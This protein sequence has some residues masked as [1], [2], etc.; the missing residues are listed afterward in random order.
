[1]R[2]PRRKAEETRQ[3][4]L[5]IAEKLFRRHGIA[6]TSVA[7]IA[8]E[9]A[10]SPANVFKHFHSKTALVDAICERHVSRMIEQFTSM[11]EPAPAPERLAR[12]VCRLM[13]THLQHI[14]ENPFFLEMIFVM[15]DTQLHSGRRY[16]ALIE[17]LFGDLIRQGAESG[18]YRCTD[19]AATS[20]Y[21]SAAFVSVLHPVFL[22]DADRD[23]LR[24]RCTGLAALVNAALQN[25]LAK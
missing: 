14:R 6:K 10:M 15:S 18:V 11:D 13:E 12:V 3:D 4:I 7:D 16:G 20:R 1:M 22:A 8:V 19:C 5:A 23:E 21:V 17:E 9:L 25:G 2:R 24:D